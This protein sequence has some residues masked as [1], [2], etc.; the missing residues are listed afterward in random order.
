MFRCAMSEVLLSKVE[1][2]VVLGRLLVV[3]HREF[4]GL[5]EFKRRLINDY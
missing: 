3:N 2:S 5:L 1:K 4:F